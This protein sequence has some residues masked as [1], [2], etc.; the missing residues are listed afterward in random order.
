MRL[1]ITVTSAIGGK[2]WDVGVG[3]EISVFPKR[4]MSEACENIP[5][6]V[7]FFV[8]RY[9]SLKFSFGK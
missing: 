3:A 5:V 9:V 8:E 7:T 1:A 2:G 6:S 4:P